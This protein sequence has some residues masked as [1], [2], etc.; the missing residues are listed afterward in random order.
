MREIVALNIEETRSYHRERL[1]ELRP[2][3]RRYDIG[4]LVLARRSVRSNKA[5]NVVDKTEFAFT[6]PWSVTKKLKGASYELTHTVT[7]KTTTKHAMHMSP[8]PPDMQAFA[9]LDGVDSRYGQLYRPINSEAYKLGGVDGF[10]PH[11]PFKDFKFCPDAV[12]V[13]PARLARSCAS[14]DPCPIMPCLADLNEWLL[15]DKNESWTEEELEAAMYPPNPSCLNVQAMPTLKP[16]P[17]TRPSINE[18]HAK[19][20]HGRNNLFFVSEKSGA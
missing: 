9:P 16:K 13:A 7:K 20:I 15:A 3:P 1:N 4:D 6:G 11:N 8:V 18:L 5:K 12:R 17:V 14:V 2:D 19:L 10:L